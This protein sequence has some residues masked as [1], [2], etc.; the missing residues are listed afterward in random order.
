M[1]PSFDRMTPLA[2]ERKF[3]R[4]SLSGILRDNASLP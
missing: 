2:I 1:R 3:N 4:A